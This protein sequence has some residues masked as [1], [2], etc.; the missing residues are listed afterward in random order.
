MSF[1][2]ML[3]VLNEESDRQGRRAGRL[4]PRL[5]RRHLRH[6]R[7]HDQRRGPRPAARHHRLPACTCATSRTATSCTSSRGA[8]RAFPVVKDLV[9]DRSAFDRIIAAGGFISRRHRQRARRQRHPGPQGQRRARHGR[10]RLHRLRRLRGHVPQRLGV[11]VHR[12]QDL[13]PRPAAARPARARAAAPSPWWRKPTR[14]C[15]AAAPIGECEAV[16]PKDIKLEVIARM[17]RDFLSANWAGRVG[18]EAD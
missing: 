7:L 6:V 15:S 13:A 3:D 2:E 14:R 11:A 12:R 16:C 9:V 17:N 4:R 1:L 10:R 5:P 18:V 8:P